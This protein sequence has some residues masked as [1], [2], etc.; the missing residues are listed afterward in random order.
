MRTISLLVLALGASLVLADIASAQQRRQRGG[1]GGFGRGGFGF[2]GPTALLT[3]A[4]V[5]EELKLTD[6]Q[7][8]K[9]RESLKEI[10]AGQR[11]LFGQL[12]DLSDEERREKLAALRK[13]MTEKTEKIVSEVLKPEQKK[14]LTQIQLQQAGVLGYEQNEEVQKVLKLTDEQK[15]KLSAINEQV[16]QDMRDLFQGA[17]GGDRAEL[18]KKM[19]ALRTES[20]EKAMAVLTDEQKAA[21]KEATGEP[22]QVRFE[23]RGPRNR[24]N[25]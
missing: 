2:G 3:N 4:S 16:R 25:N 1:P 21:W 13:E 15:Q 22:F 8:E 14:R 12:R 24:D 19:T 20:Q 10:T 11:E 6:E 5:A 7:R 17:Q 9:L 18:A 23:G